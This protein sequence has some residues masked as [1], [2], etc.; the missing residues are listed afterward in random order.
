[1]DQ[2]YRKSQFNYETWTENGHLIYNTMYNSLVR[3]NEAEYL[4]YAGLEFTDENLCKKLYDLGIL[5]EKDINELEIYN[6]YTEF[7]RKYRNRQINLT[8]TPTM[9][10]NARCF[11]CYENGSQTRENV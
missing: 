1:M 10:C 7:A 6:V 3:L 8:V 2:N 9:A 11:Y 5:M 4:Q